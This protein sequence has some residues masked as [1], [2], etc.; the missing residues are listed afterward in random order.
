MMTRNVRLEPEPQALAANPYDPRSFDSRIVNAVA[1]PLVAGL[2]VLA[3]MSPLGMLFDGFH[4]WVHEFGHATVAWLSGMRAL[5]VP[6]GW[7]NIEEDKSPLV[8][9]GVPLLL[10]VLAVAGWRERKVWPMVLAALLL[11]AQVYM[12]WILPEDRDRMWRIFAGVGGEFY[13]SSAMIGLFYFEFPEKFKWGSCRYVFLFIGAGTFFQSFSFWRDVKHG[14]EGIPYGSMINGEGDGGG[15][16]NILRED[17]HWT[18][19]Q[20]I[21][22]YN[23]LADACLV[24]LAVVYIVFNLRLDRIFDRWLARIL[25]A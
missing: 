13:L 23:H 7:T 2:A 1:P 4:V 14:L 9:V 10:G 21:Y 15:D 18:Q 25:A 8:Y 3:K 11:A 22:T 5:P 6:F 20:I 24:S 17:Y 16:M 12:T 19:H